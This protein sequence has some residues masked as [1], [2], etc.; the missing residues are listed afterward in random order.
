MN[1]EGF[2]LKREKYFL[3]KR[4]MELFDRLHQEGEL[5]TEKFSQISKKYLLP[6]SENG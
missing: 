6:I 4:V 5:S 3:I 2:N 1:Q